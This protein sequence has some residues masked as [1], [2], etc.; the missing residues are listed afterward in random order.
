[1][2]DDRRSPKP[3][4]SQNIRDLAGELLRLSRDDPDQLARRVAALDIRQQAELALR[5]PAQQR[6]ELLLH[7]PKPMRLVRALPDADLYLTVREIGP[8]DAMPL[9]GLASSSQLLHL[10]DLESWR[11]DR[12]DADRSGAWVA[13]L[14]DA[15]EPSLSRFLRNADDEL[16]SLL[17]RH[18]IR[19][20]QIEYEDSPDVHGHGEGDGGTEQGFMTPDGYYRFSPTIQEHVAAIRRILQLFYTTS[21]DRY[22]SVIWHAI[23]ELPAELEE[24]ALQWRQSRLEEHGFPTR[25][26]ALS[27]YAAPEGIRVHPQPLVPE[28]PDALPASRRPVMLSL[29]A[30]G[31]LVDAIERLPP[32]SRESVLHALVSLANHVIVADAT[33]T[34]EPSSHI[35]ALQK[36]A[37]YV[38][39]ALRS[40]GA[41][42]QAMIGATLSDVP[43]IE[44]FR[45]GYGEAVG[46][47]HRAHAMVRDGWASAHP[48]ALELLEAPIADRVLGLLEPRP[49]FAEFDEDEPSVR[50]RDF[51]S[52]K[53]LDETRAAFEMS[54]VV[55]RLF[56]ERLGFD[57]GT[58]VGHETVT[59]PMRLSAMF[60]TALA[61][62]ATGNEVAGEPLPGDVMAQFLRTVASRRTAS[63]EA[64]GRALEMLVRHL[65]ER[66]EL[67]AR[68]VSV[69]QAFGRFC[70][71]KL[72]AECAALDPGVPVDPRLVTCL[73]IAQN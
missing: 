43:V 55:G 11:G 23:W 37:G 28:D 6:V 48:R 62:H 14:L 44:L 46:L 45:E 31:G 18:W 19:V 9:I 58:W 32:D 27:I 65:T 70:L 66:F 8:A 40:R 15:G 17:F 47:Q 67:D 51:Q 30:P 3:V 22:Q 34:G 24:R 69:L 12:F 63:P 25:E 33:D 2:N 38:A 21:P 72:A 52:P 61:W 71:G 41:T 1:M 26:E 54:E 16:L 10:M 56:V 29:D 20:E 42:E 64:P 5:L 4:P 39:I 49:L 59:G 7:A 50:L 73:L 35:T 13:L 60:L 36:A 68:E 53:E 57:A